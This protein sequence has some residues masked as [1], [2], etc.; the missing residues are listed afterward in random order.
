MNDEPLFDYAALDLDQVYLTREDLRGYLDQRDAVEQ[1][2]HVI[3][4]N[5]D[6][7]RALGIRTVGDDEWWVSGHIPGNP[8]LPGVLMVETAAQ[9]SAFLYY[10]K[11]SKRGVEAPEFLA[12]AG[13][14]DTRFRA[15]ARPGD[16]MLFVIK[17]VRCDRRIVIADTQALVGPAGGDRS[18]M[19]F[20]FHTQVIGMPLAGARA[21]AQGLTNGEGK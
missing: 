10:H 19:E 15:S 20:A 21:V 13:L 4:V 17:E 1:L 6:S 14:K 2:E 12:F 9:F 3:W 8:I 7:S 11:M 18:K 5:E 16:E